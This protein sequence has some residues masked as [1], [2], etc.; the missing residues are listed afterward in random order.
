MAWVSGTGTA[1]WGGQERGFAFAFLFY[2]AN[3]KTGSDWCQ[4][5]AGRW[6]L[7]SLKGNW[8]KSSFKCDHSEDVKSL[9]WVLSCLAVSN[10]AGHILNVIKLNSTVLNPILSFS[11]LCCNDEIQK[12]MVNVVYNFFF[13]VS[14]GTVS[15]NSLN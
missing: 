9:R 8:Q 10:C 5:C 6:A 13:P 4:V 15:N 11:V 14:S 2:F 1:A 12:W 3:V 7:E